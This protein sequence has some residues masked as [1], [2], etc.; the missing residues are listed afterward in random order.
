M[1]LMMVKPEKSIREV[2]FNS[3]L[4]ISRGAIFQPDV[5][6]GSDAEWQ[7]MRLRSVGIYAVKIRHDLLID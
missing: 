5:A 7:Q 1:K 4:I 2:Y 6:L 3:W